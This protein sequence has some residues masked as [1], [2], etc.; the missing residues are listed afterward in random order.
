MNVLGS[1]PFPRINDVNAK[2]CPMERIIAFAS[3]VGPC[4]G[5]GVGTKMHIL[6]L[7][8]TTL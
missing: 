1:Q 6:P 7:R 5:K 2:L 4:V 8:M 3:D